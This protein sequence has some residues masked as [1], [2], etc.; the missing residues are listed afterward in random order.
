MYTSPCISAAGLFP[1]EEKSQYQT[2]NIKSINPTVMN[3]SKLFKFAMVT[4]VAFLAISCSGITQPSADEVMDKINNSE[5]LEAADYETILDYLEE[6]CDDGETRDNTYEEGQALGTEHPYFLPFALV[7]DNA[8][9][10]VKDE[11]RYKEIT[12]RFL[13]LMNR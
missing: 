1:E 11:P 8:P 9:Q 6:F 13:V 4:L 5:Q 12:K 10:E 2:I 3:I 7:L